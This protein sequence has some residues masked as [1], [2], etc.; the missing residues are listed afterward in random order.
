MALIS[1]TI[2]SFAETMFMF[3]FASGIDSF[4]EK[5]TLEGLPGFI[6]FYLLVCFNSRCYGL[7]LYP[8]RW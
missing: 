2:V 1:I 4:I 8:L 6:A 7:C 5:N 3:Q